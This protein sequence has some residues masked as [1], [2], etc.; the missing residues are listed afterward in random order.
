[1]HSRSGDE[2]R[3]REVINKINGDFAD[4]TSLADEA[5]DSSFRECTEHTVGPRGEEARGALN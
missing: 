5:S 1:M 2:Q 3:E 4:F